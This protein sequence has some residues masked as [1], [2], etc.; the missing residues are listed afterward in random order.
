MKIL[1]FLFLVLWPL[2]PGSSEVI[3]LDRILAVVNGEVIS[4]SDVESDLFF[5]SKVEPPPQRD[6]GRTLS[7]S[8]IRTGIRELINQ[9]LLLAEA[10]RFDV[11]DPTERQIAEELEIIQ[12]RFPSPA[13]YEMARRRNAMTLEDLRQRVKEH[14]RVNRF[15]DQRIRFFVIVLPEEISQYYSENQEKFQHKTYE[16]AEKEIEMFLTEAKAKEKLE[17]YLSN[18]KTKASI[19]INFE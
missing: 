1:F 17:A 16:E 15:I 19:Q 12:N 8:A 7:D 6:L 4:L 14:L 9:K 18:L 2:Q 13:A 3:V 11:E 5:F 10:K